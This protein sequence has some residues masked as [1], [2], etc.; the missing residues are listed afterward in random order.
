MRLTTG[1][2]AN[3]AGSK[4]PIS[5]A[6]AGSS[7]TTS[8]LLP[9]LF[10]PS[11]RR[12]ALG[13]EPVITRSALLYFDRRLERQHGRWGPRPNVYSRVRR[14]TFRWDP[15]AID[16]PSLRRARHDEVDPR[17][18]RAVPQRDAREP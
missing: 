2:C 17:V 3:R 4:N 9:L 11:D 5:S 6:R 14:E 15:G 1:T 13:T 10:F 16:C 18:Q 12:T 8:R 7:G